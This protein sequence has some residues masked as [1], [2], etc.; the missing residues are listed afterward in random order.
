LERLRQALAFEA[1]ASGSR[2][3][4]L[5]ADADRSPEDQIDAMFA[6]GAEWLH[7][8]NSEAGCFIATIVGA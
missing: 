1:R 4:A 3:I 5:A 6:A 2:V 7:L 8:R